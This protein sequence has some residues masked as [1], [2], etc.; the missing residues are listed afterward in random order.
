MASLDSLLVSKV[1][2]NGLEKSEYCVRGFWD[3]NSFKSIKVS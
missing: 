3:N 1:A 2:I